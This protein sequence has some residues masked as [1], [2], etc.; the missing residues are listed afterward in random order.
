VFDVEIENSREFYNHMGHDT[1]HKTHSIYEGKQHIRKRT[2]KEVRQIRRKVSHRE[3]NA[4]GNA[5]RINQGKNER[6]CRI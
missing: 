3:R 4:I 1:E 6:N 5:R 2:K